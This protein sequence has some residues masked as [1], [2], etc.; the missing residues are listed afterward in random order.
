MRTHFKLLSKRYPY[1]VDLTIF[2]ILLIFLRIVIIYKKL[3][4][5]CTLKNSESRYHIYHYYNNIIEHYYYIC[6]QKFEPKKSY[7]RFDYV[8]IIRLYKT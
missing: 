3:F 7:D 1:I 8:D 5:L 4:F 2:T 6:Y